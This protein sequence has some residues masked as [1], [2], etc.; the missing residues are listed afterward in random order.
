VIF[1]ADGTK[2]RSLQTPTGTPLSAAIPLDGGLLAVGESGVQTL[3]S[4]K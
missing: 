2:V 1:I 4:L 3:A